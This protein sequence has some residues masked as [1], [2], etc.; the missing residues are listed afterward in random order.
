MSNICH[1]HQVSIFRSN[2]HS[3]RVETQ[4]I[5]CNL[6]FVLLVLN[7]L[8]QIDRRQ[9]NQISEIWHNF[10]SVSGLS[11]QMPKLTPV[12]KGRF[13]FHLHGITASQFRCFNS[14]ELSIM[15][16]SQVWAWNRPANV[17]SSLYSLA[18]LLLLLSS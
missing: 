4:H 12:E 13:N 18:F 11:H 3:L 7:R 6:Y 9:D 15:D 1:H 16:L 10:V 2:S 17:S 5:N 8:D 14:T